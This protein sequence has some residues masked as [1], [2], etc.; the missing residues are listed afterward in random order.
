MAFKLEKIT[1]SHYKEYKCIHCLKLCNESQYWLIS[2]PNN[3]NLGIFHFNC[4]SEIIRNNSID[5]NIKDIWSKRMIKQMYTPEQLIDIIKSLEIELNIEK[6][7]NTSLSNEI[8]FMKK[9]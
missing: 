5:S 4:A 8:K 9:S 1:T 2:E 3:E 7:K 6:E